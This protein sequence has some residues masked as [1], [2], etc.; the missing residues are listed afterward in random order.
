MTARIGFLGGA[1]LHV[2]MYAG[3][4]SNVG[5]DHGHWSGAG[6]EA[7]E[8]VELVGI[9]DDD[10][11]RGREVADRLDVDYRPAN[12][13]L[14]DIDG[15]IVTAENT[16]HRRWI[17]AAADRGV[18]VLSEKPLGATVEAARESV[19]VCDAAG[20]RL[21]VAMPLRFSQPVRRAKRAFAAGEVGTVHTVSGANR[22]S[23][24]GD[25]R[26]W[27]GDPDLAGGGAV[28]DHTV[29]LVDAV[30]WLTGE[31]VTEVYAEL[32]TRFHDGLAVEDV[33]VLSMEL[34]GGAQ[35]L[36]D[37]SWSRPDE[38]HTWGDVLLEVSGTQGTVSVDAF[39]QSLTHTRDAGDDPGIESVFW[40]TDPNEG[41]LAD[42]V[43]SVRD[44]RP[45]ETT[46]EDGVE[47]VAVVEAAYE[48]AE[49]G[50]TAAVEY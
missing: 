6:S 32:E 33:N 25:E 45:M 2:E 31:R 37:G 20:V 9:A 30:H 23:Y 29:H 21:G 39:A 24:P 41:L 50:E 26:G 22:G 10:E 11:K 17:E 48:S 13:L 5:S 35:F 8:D 38:W 16:R 14:A 47:A 46:G 15:V 3:V 36:L 49:R 19:A 44:D 4:L 34:S 27:F 1:H 43:E 7:F 42:F 40:G 28:V 12:E 18:H